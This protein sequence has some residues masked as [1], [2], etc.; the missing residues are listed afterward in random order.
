MFCCSWTSLQ[1]QNKTSS[2]T[3]EK[4]T[5][6]YGCVTTFWVSNCNFN[7]RPIVW[8][9]FRS[10]MIYSKNCTSLVPNDVAKN[11]LAVQM[12][13]TNS[14]MLYSVF[15]GQWWQMQLDVLKSSVN[16][17]MLCI[18]KL[19]NKT[20]PPTADADNQYIHY[21]TWVGCQ[22]VKIQMNY[23]VVSWFAILACQFQPN[24]KLLIKLSLLSSSCEVLFLTSVQLTC[25]RI[26]LYHS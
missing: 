16:L 13:L 14:S 5:N 25:W 7:N 9:H 22:W 18:L 1:T 17:Q 20:I 26:Q 6:A 4:L 15:D 11:G 21:I 8:R 19:Q 10:K 23:Q 24:N 3:Q 2:L 12:Y